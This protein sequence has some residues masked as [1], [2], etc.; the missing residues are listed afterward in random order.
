MRRTVITI[1]TALLGLLFGIAG[2]AQKP[3]AKPA[4]SKTQS[5]KPSSAKVATEKRPAPEKFVPARPSPAWSVAFSP[6]SKRLLVGSYKVILLYDVETGAKVG[7][8]NVA[9]EAVRSI[10]FSPEGDRVAVGIGIP[11]KVGKAVVLDSTTGK[12]TRTIEGHTDTVESVAF[13]GRLLLTASSDEK[14]QVTD[15]ATGKATGT[16]SE[17]NGRCLTVAV[18]LKTNEEAGGEIFATGGSDHMLKIWDAKAQRVVVNFDQCASPVWSVASRPV[19]GHFIAGSGDGRILYF[20]VV[21]DKDGTAASNGGIPPRTGYLEREFRAH[22]GGTYAVAVAPND[23]FLVSGGAD[24][25]AIIWNMGGG[26]RRELLGATGDIWSVAVSPDSQKIATASL[27]GKVRL[28][29]SEKGKFLREYPEE[30][31]SPEAVAGVPAGILFTPAPATGTGLKA[32]YFANTELSGK[33]VISRVDPLINFEWYTANGPAPTLP[34]ENFSGR[35]T[36][37][38][39]APTTGAYTF[40][41]VSDDGVRLWVN[42]KLLIDNWTDHGATEDTTPS[43][44]LR[45]G[46]VIPVR[47]EHYQGG[48]GATLRLYWSFAGGEAQPIPTNRMYP[49]LEPATE[50]VGGTR[51]YIATEAERGKGQG[52]V[53]YYFNNVTLEGQPVARHIDP[54]IEFVTDGTKP[55]KP[56]L[57]AQMFSVRW[58]G[59]LEA[60]LTG[61]YE[62]SVFS[63]DGVR[64]TV[65]NIQIINDWVSRGT[66]ESKGQTVIP[67]TAGQRV[68]IQLDYFQGGGTGEVRLRWSYNGQPLQPIAPKYLYPEVGIKP[69]KPVPKPTS[70]PTKTSA[71]QGKKP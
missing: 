18:P 27:D 68:P 10:V 43:I 3:P 17:H 20:G 5:T 66:T 13:A 42:S 38:V 30:A 62:F 49:D 56:N 51:F 69:K 71:Q 59:W 52:L 26:K 58:E 53:G 9:P 7:E 8:W 34:G 12:P 55:Y 39:E 47:L 23:Q 19:A 41:T 67:L 33:P 15:V 22:E 16:L 61:N 45:A 29:D 50:P 65:D 24:S 32:Q 60:P 11:G 46:Q 28:Y 40:H 35:Y 2:Y 44:T 4:K 25:K 36:G 31:I 54:T 70:K 57:P 6:D 64:L 63:D 37:W 14:V 48:G 1:S 21:K